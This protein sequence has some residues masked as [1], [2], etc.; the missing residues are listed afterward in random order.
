MFTVFIP[1]KTCSYN[2]PWK[3]IY[4]I[5]SYFNKVDSAT[6][7]QINYDLSAMLLGR[8]CIFSILT[9]IY[10]QS[11][12]RYWIV[13]N[14]KFTKFIT[15]CAS[16][17]ISTYTCCILQHLNSL[18]FDLNAFKAQ[19]AISNQM[20]SQNDSTTH[21]AL[22][23]THTLPSLSL[24]YTLTQYPVTTCGVPLIWN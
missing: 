22:H 17:W 15:N 16:S 9:F 8:V 18:R 3:R 5:D 7:L 4:S 24:A 1:F 21:W 12:R 2:T 13:L 20:A 10:M 6:E 11:G 14:G 23:H 19:V